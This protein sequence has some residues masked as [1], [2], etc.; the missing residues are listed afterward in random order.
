MRISTR[1]L[2]FLAAAFLMVAPVH[3]QTPPPAGPS[4]AEADA[5]VKLLENDAERTKLIQQLKAISAVQAPAEPEAP[6]G[7]VSNLLANASDGIAKAGS[8]FADA[9]R[10][11]KDIPAAWDSLVSFSSDPQRLT[12]WGRLAGQIG[13]V[14]GAA[15]LAEWI[16]FRLLTRP[17]RMLNERPVTSIVGRTVIFILRTIIDAVPIIVFGGVAVVVLGLLE[18]DRTAR[19][20]VTTLINA[21]MLVR[22]VLAAGRAVLAPDNNRYR[23]VRLQDETANYHYLWLRRF[24][25]VA[26]Y[27]LMG[28]DALR[29]LGF[30]ASLVGVLS[31][32]IGLILATMAIVFVLQNKDAVRSY[33][34]SDGPES[35]FKKWAGGLS[36]V[37]RRLADVWHILA[38]LYIGAV[39]A[40]W[41]MSIPG[42]FTFL[43]RGTALT[44]LLWLAV[45][46]G[47]RGLKRSLQAGFHVRGDT[48]KRFPN[49]EARANRYLPVM[50]IALRVAVYFIAAMALLQI[51]G[52]DSL[53]WLTE[54]AGRRVVSSAF[55]IGLVLALSVIVWEGA[56]SL[57][58]RYLTETDD[59]GIIR[60]RSARVR[61]LL[62]LLRNALLVILTVMA[63]L[64][65]LA[66]LGL[67]IAPLLAGAGVLGLA[68]GFGAQTLVKDVI[69]GLFMLFE[70]TVSIGDVVD[71]G[72]GNS[73]SVEGITIRTLR[74]RDGSG[75][76][77]TIP[78]S[79]ITS[80]KNMTRNFAV[81]AIDINVDYNTD[82]DHV[83]DLLLKID[84]EI[85]NDP[86]F[87]GFILRPLDFHGVD[88]FGD[89]GVMIKSSSR[90]AA[91]KQ[92]AV[93]REFFRRIKLAFDE[94][95]VSIPFPQRVVRHIMDPNGPK[96]AKPPIVATD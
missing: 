7:W 87:A 63:T 64:I 42:G 9:A 76:V 10:G 62:P 43:L 6:S 82:V 71:V 78:F 31:R 50:D 30:G 86:A 96:D 55:L 32:M 24:V 85:R 17:R 52:L 79:N 90:T 49:L 95:K 75:A 66:E 58:E 83:R 77:L 5:V 36:T 47:V 84:E 54:G 27:G 46:F 16:V 93:K 15:L 48:A 41:A 59:K 2:A 61:T 21:N 80:V 94:Q 53:V 12:K 25:G 81:A 18:P 92:W 65:V 1:F 89:N 57:I 23:L 91:G 39:F 40:V 68:I 56:S 19:L 20:I 13:V 28:L 38:I 44:F 45:R 72:G 35:R 8:E 3:A 73:G 88:S 37:R 60:Q 29:Y 51:W 11:L 34:R 67:N 22:I 74:I 70:D 69:T 33:L 14:L 4:K 26:I